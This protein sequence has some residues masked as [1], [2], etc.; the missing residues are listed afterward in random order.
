MELA[1]LNAA[2]PAGM[3]KGMPDTGP[4]DIRRFSY[5]ATLEILPE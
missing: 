5:A 4:A 2:Y 1:R 3:E